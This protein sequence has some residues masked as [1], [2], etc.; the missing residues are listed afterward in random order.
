MYEIGFGSGLGFTSSPNR[1][2]TPSTTSRSMRRARSST[3]RIAPRAALNPCT[4]S[5]RLIVVSSCPGAAYFAVIPSS[6]YSKL[7]NSSRYTW[8]SAAGGKSEFAIV[9]SQNQFFEQCL[10]AWH[11]E[12]VPLYFKAQVFQ[13]FA[14]RIA[15]AGRVHNALRATECAIEQRHL[16][17]P[18]SSSPFAKIFPLPPHGR[19]HQ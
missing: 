19:L 16:A 10:T 12:R 1:S 13:L 5:A 17:E 3:P 2:R 9:A 4:A 11:R 18:A 6:T 8:N 15:Y 7:S 14:N